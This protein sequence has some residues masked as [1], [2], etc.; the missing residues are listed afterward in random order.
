MTREEK[1]DRKKR[2]QR[3]ELAKPIENNHLESQK[4]F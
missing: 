3:V 4:M 1:K 2:R